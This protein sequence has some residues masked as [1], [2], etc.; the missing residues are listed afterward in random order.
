MQL[1]YKTNKDICYSDLI[2]LFTQAG[3]TD[4]IDDLERLEKMV[5]NSQI[6][7][8]AW[9]GTH[10]IGF[11]RCTTDYVFNG[12]INNVVVHSN[13]FDRG[14]GKELINIILKSSDKVSYLLRG[15]PHNINFY[16]SLGFESTDNAFIYKRDG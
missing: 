7:V 10:M 13:Y 3:W 9:M 11:A 12:Q 4:K 15:D 8:S 14:I 16:K 6:V 5:A 1:E 2:I